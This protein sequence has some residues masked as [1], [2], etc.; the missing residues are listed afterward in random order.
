MRE[1][2]QSFLER[3][4]GTRVVVDDE[5]TPGGYGY[6]D[7]GTDNEEEWASEEE[8]V[9]P[10]DAENFS[11]ENMWGEPAGEERYGLDEEDGPANLAIDLYESDDELIIQ[12]MIAGVTPENLRLTIT[13]TTVTLWG[14]RVPPQGIPESDYGIRELYWGEFSRTIRLPFEID[15]EK[16][17]AVEK[18]G[19]LAI[20]LPKL[21][22]TRT[23]EL[24]IKSLK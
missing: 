20:R 19:L 17:E 15:T 1:R 13:R 4:T 12:T 11:L 7:Q 21:D 16:A 23:Q 24:K 8:I 10:V 14:K 9:V 6:R 18:Y 2:K 3:L 5:N 22:V